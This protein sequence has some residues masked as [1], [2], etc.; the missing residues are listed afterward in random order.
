MTDL[1]ETSA[2]LP[3]AG[4]YPDHTGAPG[5]RWWNG[6]AWTEAT[7]SS[8]EYPVPGAT[9]Y[10]LQQAPAKV[11]AGTAV[12]NPFIWTLALLPLLGIVTLLNRDISQ[13]VQS[14]TDPLA[15]YRDP[16][17]LASLALG[18]GLYGVSVVLAY[19]DRKRLLKDGYDRPFHWAWTFLTSGVYV[20][21][22][23]VIVRRRAGRGQAPIWVW[24]GIVVAVTTIN[25]IQVGQAVATMMSTIPFSA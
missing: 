17:Y 10:A 12:Y 23:S 22:R 13:L 15:I 14:S 4:W 5:V 3:P 9:P 2:V 21:G 1:P 19:L 16:A 25:L 8:A 24:V 6:A 11:P 20:I 7:R 18:W